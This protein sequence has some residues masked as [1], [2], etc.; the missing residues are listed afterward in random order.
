MRTN[1]VQNKFTQNLGSQSRAAQRP[2]SQPV[3]EFL[4][5]IRCRFSKRAQRLPT[6]GCR[7][8]ASA[9][10]VDAGHTAAI[11]LDHRQLAPL[12]GVAFLAEANV[13]LQREQQRRL[14]TGSSAL[15]SWA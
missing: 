15:G 7:P 14:Y 12:A 13:T 1:L 2:K 6:A 9:Q 5:L 3:G 8:A 10:G 4:L 11:D